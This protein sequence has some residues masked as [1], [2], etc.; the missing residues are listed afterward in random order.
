[1]PA[2]VCLFHNLCHK[3]C[4]IL[5]DIKSC[6]AIIKFDS[7][8]YSTG[9]M[10]TEIYRPVVL[11]LITKSIVLVYFISSRYQCIYC[12]HLIIINRGAYWRVFRLVTICQCWDHSWGRNCCPGQDWMKSLTVDFNLWSSKSWDVSHTRDFA[13]HKT[14][15]LGRVRTFRS[16]MHLRSWSWQRSCT[17]THCSARWRLNWCQIECSEATHPNSIG[18]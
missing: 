4:I 13:S 17:L 5:C 14:R 11:A 12:T 3:R 1:M 8:R 7:E 18:N 6:K 10:S 15:V 2:T 16:A 9:N